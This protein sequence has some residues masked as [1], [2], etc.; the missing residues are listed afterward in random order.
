MSKPNFLIIG[1]MKAGTT[2]LYR[3]LHGHP[4]LFLPEQKEPDTLA[5]FGDD[6]DAIH[7]DY[8]SL[9]AMAKAGQLLGEASTSY[10][11]RPD[12]GDVARRAL[13]ICGPDLKL[14]YLTRDPVKRA[15]SQYMHEFGQEQVKEPLNKA[16]L[17][18]PRFAQYSAYDY[19][20]APWITHFGEKNLLVRRFEDYVSNRSALL[21]E[22]CAF[23]GI[24]AALLPPPAEDRAFNASERKPTP[25]GIMNAFVRSRFYQRAVKP[26]VPWVLRDKVMR[27]VLP[28]VSAPTDRLEDDT[29]KSYLSSLEA[30]N[31]AEKDLP[32]TP[33][34]GN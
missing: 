18:H 26:R 22:V 32:R 23:L 20:L 27:L 24:D 25:K 14:I 21:G 1:A 28:K 16:L 5:H 2:T 10:T 34:G 9:F 15:V 6:M 12:H 17:Q 13:E 3:D 11:K 4:Q 30:Y 31:R 8:A 33:M 29:R 7:R 19:Q